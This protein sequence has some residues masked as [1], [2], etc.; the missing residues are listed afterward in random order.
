MN[1]ILPQGGSIY[2]CFYTPVIAEVLIVVRD[3]NSHLL[4]A[5]PQITCVLS[6]C[7]VSVSLKEIPSSTHMN[8]QVELSFSVKVG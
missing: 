7:I 2:W 6:I 5:R 8:D 3:L 1:K 4:L